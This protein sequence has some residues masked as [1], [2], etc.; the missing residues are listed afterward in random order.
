[1]H[2][3]P[4]MTTIHLSR[5][6]HGRVVAWLADGMSR[7]RNAWRRGQAR[8][9]AQHELAAVADMNELLLRDIGA[10]EWMIADAAT[11]R[12]AHEL[13]LYELQNWQGIDRL[14]GIK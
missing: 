1:M 6:L 8:R 14:R 5:P 9:R 11:R 2:A 3:Q 12:D 10:P 4:F 13:R 7:L